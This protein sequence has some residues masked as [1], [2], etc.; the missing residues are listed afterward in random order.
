M[1]TDLANLILIETGF[2]TFALIVIIYIDYKIQN[3]NTD[4]K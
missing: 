1:Y 2:I 4:D 3:R